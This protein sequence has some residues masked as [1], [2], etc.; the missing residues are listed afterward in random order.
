M[1]R[2]TARPRTKDEKVSAS[3]MREKEPK[4]LYLNDPK[5]VSVF[6]IR[7]V[8]LK[9]KMQATLPDAQEAESD[10][11]DETWEPSYDPSVAYEHVL[12]RY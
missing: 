10:V 2:R 1:S 4:V 12:Y 9:E 8:G 11:S 3:L 7:V 5:A 6:Q